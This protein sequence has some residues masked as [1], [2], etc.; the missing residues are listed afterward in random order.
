MRLHDALEQISEIRQQVGRAVLY[1]G[2]RSSAVTV[3]AALAWAGAAAQ[4]VLV[5]E[6]MRDMTGYMAVW[7][8]VALGS[9][10]AVAWAMVKRSRTG[11]SK[12]EREQALEVAER[13]SPVLG[14]GAWLTVVLALWSRD[15]VWMLPGL[16]AV[17]FGL[18]VLSMRRMLPRLMMVVGMYYLASGLMCLAWAQGPWALSPWAMAS[19]FGVGQALAAG[20]LFWTLERPAVAEQTCE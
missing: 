2:L 20:V 16:W 3:T 12:L 19:T 1:R 6:P 7:F 9:A 5:P 13:L 17:L 8:V 10:G 15:Q 4:S 14:V 11:G 18:G